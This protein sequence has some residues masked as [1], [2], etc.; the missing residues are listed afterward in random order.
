MSMSV[1]GAKLSTSS[2]PHKFFRVA[3]GVKVGATC[4]KY[5]TATRLHGRAQA[6]MTE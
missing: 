5:A 4:R 2:R 3:E 1:N 6:A